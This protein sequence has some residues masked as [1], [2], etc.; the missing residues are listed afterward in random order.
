RRA[1]RTGMPV[2]ALRET[3]IPEMT[4]GV[5]RPRKD[6]Q[7]ASIDHLVARLKIRRIIDD[8]AYPSVPNADPRPPRLPAQHYEPILDRDINLHV[9]RLPLSTAALNC[10]R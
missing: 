2:L 8:G 10:R 7:S 5:D 9:I 6:H 1:A 4:M 3:G